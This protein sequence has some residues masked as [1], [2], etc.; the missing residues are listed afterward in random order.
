M[1][2]PL[3]APEG[4][5]LAGRCLA[6]SPEMPVSVS[7]LQ[8]RRVCSSKPPSLWHFLQQQQETNLRGQVGR[9]G[10]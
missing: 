10:P 7:G 3:K 5:S 4:T 1:D 2:S 8:R 9:R 6:F